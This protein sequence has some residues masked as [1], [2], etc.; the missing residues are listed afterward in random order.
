MSDASIPSFLASLEKSYEIDILYA[1][2]SGSRAWGFASPNSDYDIRFLYLAPANHYRSVFKFPD[3]IEIPIQN[4]L[5]P[6]GWDIRKALGLLSKSNGPLIEWLY[7]PTIYWNTQNL[8]E[9]W[10]ELTNHILDPNHLANH[11]RG[12]AH[13]IQK[14]KLNKSEKK[15]SAKGYLYACRALLA[16]QWVENQL[17]IPPVRFASLIDTAEPKIHEALS[18]LI[19]WKG[20]ADETASN[21]RIKVLDEFLTSNLAQEERPELPRPDSK[22]IQQLIDEEYRRLVGF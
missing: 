4:D 20:D 14:N 6:V 10:Q 5:D 22:L 16:A 15:P 11:Y 21:G 12:L 7:S 17:T 1:C 18:S 3:S 2:E 13:Q 9:K 8:R 19:I